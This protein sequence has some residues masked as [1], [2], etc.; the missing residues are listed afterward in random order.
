MYTV[1]L[2]P[3]IYFALYRFYLS[4]YFQETLLHDSVSVLLNNEKIINEPRYYILLYGKFN[5]SGVF[6]RKLN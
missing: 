3:A 2:C 1:Y 5:L 4:D 6:I